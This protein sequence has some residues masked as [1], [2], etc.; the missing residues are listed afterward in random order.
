L[1]AEHFGNIEILNSEFDV[2][3][4]WKSE[5]IN[6]IFTV[7]K[8]GKTN[9]MA[10]LTYN[11]VY[12]IKIKEQT[13]L[14]IVYLNESYLTDKCISKGIIYDIDKLLVC[15]QGDSYLYLIDRS[16][17]LVKKI[18]ATPSNHFEL[19]KLPGKFSNWHY[20]LLRDD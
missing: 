9:E 3:L 5:K 7:I 13:K 4:K 14:E 19:Q 11:G 17:K 2:E 20:A 8:A 6:T 1:L 18:K 12:F 15:V 16:K 10:L